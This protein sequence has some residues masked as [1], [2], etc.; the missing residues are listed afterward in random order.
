MTTQMPLN[1][2]ELLASVLQIIIIFML[3]RSCFYLI[4]VRKE[5]PCADMVIMMVILVTG[6]GLTSYNL[7]DPNYVLQRFPFNLMVMFGFAWAVYRMSKS[8]KEDL[9]TITNVIKRKYTGIEEYVLNKISDQALEGP[10][11]VTAD[12][13]LKFDIGKPYVKNKQHILVRLTPPKDRNIFLKFNVN[14]M[15]GAEFA[16]Q[17]HPD[18]HEELYV[19]S[20]SILDKSTGK[21]FGVGDALEIPAGTLHHIMAIELTELSSYLFKVK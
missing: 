15:A 20:G 21:I 1:Y 2:Y 10:E 8:K 16:E 6:L 7:T 12:D 3:M 14:M 18:M 5:I 17:Y 19:D 9:F 13:L 4:R 11:K